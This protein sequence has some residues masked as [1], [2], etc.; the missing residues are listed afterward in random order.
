MDKR[1][2]VILCGRSLI[3]GTVGMDAAGDRLLVLR[4]LTTDD[5]IQMIETLPQSP[6]ASGPSDNSLP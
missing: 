5:L 6:V 2:R 3:L 1:R 4:S